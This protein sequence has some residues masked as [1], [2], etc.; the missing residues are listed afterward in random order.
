V[1]VKAILAALLASLKVRRLGF[2]IDGGYLPYG[3]RADDE[4]SGEMA[5]VEIEEMATLQ[6]VLIRSSS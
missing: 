1:F 3:S 6:K 2:G 5:C 4:V